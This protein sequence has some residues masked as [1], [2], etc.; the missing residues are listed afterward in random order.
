MYCPVT[1]IH[2]AITRCAI[3]LPAH[4]GTFILYTCTFVTI[5]GQYIAL[6]DLNFMA[7]A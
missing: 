6:C 1:Y 3:I 5:P 4:E 2:I 7:C